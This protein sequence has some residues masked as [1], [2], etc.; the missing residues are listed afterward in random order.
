MP[1]DPDR[2]TAPAGTGTAPREVLVDEAGSVAESLSCRS[3]GYDLKG[4][5]N[6][7]I[8]SVLPGGK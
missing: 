5:Y 1:T 7:P 3:C 2:C 4:P 6:M 8:V